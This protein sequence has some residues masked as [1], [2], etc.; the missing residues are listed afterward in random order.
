M[1][2]GMSVV[3]PRPMIL[4]EYDQIQARDRYGA[5]DIRPGLTGWAQV[6]GRDGVTVEQKARLDGEYRQRMGLVM[7]VRVFLRSIVVVL[8]RLGY[9][10]SEPKEES[11]VVRC[12]DAKASVVAAKI[13]ESASKGHSA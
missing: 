3:G 9:A 8:G 10:E 6:N 2:K 13:N 5:N 1:T 4:A 7:D 11:G 12:A